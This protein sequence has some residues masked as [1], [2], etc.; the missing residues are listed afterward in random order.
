MASELYQSLQNVL[1]Y[2]LIP[3]MKKNCKRSVELFKIVRQQQYQHS[4]Y[5][6]LYHIIKG[7]ENQTT[8]SK[9]E[10]DKEKVRIAGMTVRMVII[11]LENHSLT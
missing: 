10:A 4:F 5:C 7:R 3:L 8:T 6:S 2:S 9:F 1:F 11:W